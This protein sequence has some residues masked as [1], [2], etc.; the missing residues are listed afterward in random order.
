MSAGDG[1]FLPRQHQ[2]S[3]HELRKDSSFISNQRLDAVFNHGASVFSELE[4]TPARVHS[5]YGGA[6]ACR[7][8]S[9]VVHTSYLMANVNLS[10]HLS[11]SQ[12]FVRFK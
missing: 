3:V 4:V 10:I 11:C 12:R 7:I 9:E 5:S 1:H 8:H 6:A 2:D